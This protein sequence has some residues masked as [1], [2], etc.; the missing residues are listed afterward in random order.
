MKKVLIFSYSLS[1]T[2]GTETVLNSWFE[3]L[4]IESGY[5]INLIIYG[6]G[7]APDYS[8]L[9]NKNV[10]VLDYKIGIKRLKVL[11]ELRK[12]IKKE[13]YDIIICLGFNL[14]RAVLMVLKTI[15][16]Q[17]YPK[18]FYWTH[19]RVELNQ[20]N[21]K[22]KKL[23]NKVD[24]I[25]SLCEEMSKQFLWF[26]VDEKKIHTIYNPINRSKIKKK[27]NSSNVF[28]YI[29][30]LD[31]N[32]KRVS[33]IIKS[34]YLLK[35]EDVDFKFNIIG[36]GDSYNFYKSLIQDFSLDKYVDIINIW[37]KDPWEFVEE[38]DC[39]ILSSNFEGFGM[40][41]A[42][43]LA[44]GVPVIASSC[45]VG[46]SDLIKKGDNGFLYPT[47]DVL[48]LKESIKLIIEKKISLSSREIQSSIERMYVE[49]YFL[50]L[51]KILEC[52]E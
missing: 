15:S 21:K 51:K 10:R 9:K 38:I 2:G 45:P 23:I 16:F 6:S 14:L 7:G 42:E 18:I 39:L 41:I 34:F 37:F 25:L 24:G 29:G 43:A 13:K 28:Y 52:S 48:S 19:F 20:F 30:R 22:N 17:K 36:V 1:G 31:E 4:T 27:S 40:V 33:D 46:P 49:N 35:R 8:F 11:Y 5:D 32:Q 47:G 26:S 44:R 12:I 3:N 50:N